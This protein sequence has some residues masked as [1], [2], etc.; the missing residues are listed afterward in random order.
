MPFS[1]FGLVRPQEASSHPHAIDPRSESRA[2][3]ARDSFILEED[4]RVNSVKTPPC[5]LLRL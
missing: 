4:Y 1:G 3:L 2:T 5:R